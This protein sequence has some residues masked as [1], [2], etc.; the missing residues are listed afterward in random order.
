M[1]LMNFDQIITTINESLPI[2]SMW[3]GFWI[4]KFKRK[5]LIISCSFDRIYYR[6]YDLIFKKVTFFNVPDEWRDTQIHGDELIRLAPISE[7]KQYHPDF[8]VQDQLIFAVDIF[9][10]NN[11]TLEKHIF[12]IL[13]KHIYLKKCDAPDN[14]PTPE[15]ADPFCNEFFPCRKNRI[16][17]K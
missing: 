8:N 2:H 15:Y 7:F 13:A 5:T 3:D 9:F 11:S 17:P 14:N 12:F 1:P 4:H 16:V 6:N 10:D